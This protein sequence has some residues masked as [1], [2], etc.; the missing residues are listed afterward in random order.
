MSRV[1]VSIASGRGV[2]ERWRSQYQDANGRWTRVVR[3]QSEN[4]YEKLCSLGE[5]PD[6]DK[7]AEII[8]NKS[9]GHLTCSG[10]NEHVKRTATFSPEYSDNPIYLCHNC[11]KDAVRALARK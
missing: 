9:W 6:I 1:F 8:G 10:C 5:N 7:I 4:I 3:G 2:A 11:A